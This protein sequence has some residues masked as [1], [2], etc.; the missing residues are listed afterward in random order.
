VLTW[1]A[2]KTACPEPRLFSYA[3]VGRPAEFDAYCDGS[4]A[5]NGFYGYGIVD[6]LKALSA[7]FAR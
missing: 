5:F 4:P 7:P 2:Q 3:N 6:A 1:S